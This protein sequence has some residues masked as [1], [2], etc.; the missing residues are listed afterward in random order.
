M[1]IAKKCASNRPMTLDITT[2]VQAEQMVYPWS[3][4]HS[5]VKLDELDW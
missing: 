5:E 3:E 2:K 4:I 1:L